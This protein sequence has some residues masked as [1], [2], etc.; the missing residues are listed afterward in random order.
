MHHLLS[1]FSSFVGAQTWI[2]QHG[3]RVVALHGTAAL[4][5]RSHGSP[6]CSRRRYVGA[7]TKDRTVPRNSHPSSATSDPRGNAFKSS[8]IPDYPG[9]QAIL[10]SGLHELV[11]RYVQ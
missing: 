6:A 5:R 10:A 1:Q 9:G 11:S 8:D 4:R 7:S 3:T 2:S